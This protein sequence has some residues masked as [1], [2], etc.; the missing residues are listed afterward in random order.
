MSS[1][2]EL[3]NV[4]GRRPRPWIERYL[5]A[6]GPNRPTDVERELRWAD[7]MFTEARASGNP[8]WVWMA[9]RHFRDHDL[10]LPEWIFVYF[11]K[12]AKRL[13]ANVEL[14]PKDPSSAV[15]EALFMKWRGRG[16]VFSTFRKID[17]FMAAME[18]I[19]AR[20]RGEGIH[21]G[22]ARAAQKLETDKRTA[23]RHRR[24]ILK[25]ARE[26]HAG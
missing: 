22:A 8:L 6:L 10:P 11:D 3:R 20:L 15:A 7:S 25:H 16:S 4:W 23:R 9:F 24:T 2:N 14:P 17:E 26:R 13:Q 21:V 5:Q 18:M 19:Q 12:V 1:R